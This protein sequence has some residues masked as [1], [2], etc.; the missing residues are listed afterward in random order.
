MRERGS[1]G[2][3]DFLGA[4]IRGLHS[5]FPAEEATMLAVDNAATFY[6]AGH[7]T[8]ANALAWALYL[9]ANTPMAQERARAEARAAL[10]D[11]DLATLPD[12]LP[13]LRQVLDETLRL[14]PPA[15]RFER[16]AMGEDILDGQ[17]IRRGDVLCRSGP[18]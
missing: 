15:P 17:R 3:D 11:A 5:Q 1:D 2:G 14:Y 18:G 8:T 9:L 10:A 12:R 13:Y 4:V 16:E 6:V 7:E